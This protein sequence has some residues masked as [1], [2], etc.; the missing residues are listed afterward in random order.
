MYKLDPKSLLESKD[1]IFLHLSSYKTPEKKFDI[2]MALTREGISEAIGIGLTHTY[3]QINRLKEKG[4]I[5]TLKGRARGKSRNQEFFYLSSKGTKYA[6]NLKKK[7][8]KMK[9]DIIGIPDFQDR[10]DLDSALDILKDADFHELT[11]LDICRLTN[12]EGVLDVKKLKKGK[13]KIYVEATSGVPEIIHFFGRKDEVNTIRKW[14]SEK[15]KHNIIFIHGMAGIGKTTLA[16]RILEDYHNSKH[17]FWHEFHEMD[18]I[19]GI[20]LKLAGFFTELGD[21][22]LELFLRTRTGYDHYE[23]SRILEKTVKKLDAILVFDDFQKSSDEIRKFFVYFLGI[24]SP[25]SNTKLMILSREIVPFYDSRA[26]IAKKTVGELSLEGL[27]FESSKKLLKEKGVKKG[28]YKDIYGITAGNPLFLEVFQTQGHLDR[29]VHDELFAK[30]EKKEKRILSCLSV[31]RYPVKDVFLS[32]CD[33]L[34][35][36]TLYNLNRKSIVKK[37][38]YDRYFIHD[39]LKNFFYSRLS[40]RERNELH[41]LIAQWYVND[42]E[43]ANLIEAIYHYQEADQVNEAVKVSMEYSNLIIERGMAPDFLVLLN[44]FEGKDLETD[45]FAEILYIKGKSSYMIGE[46][47]KGLQYFS[48][49]SDLGA[50]INNNKLAIKAICESGYILEEYNVMDKSIM[51][52]EKGLSISKKEKYPYGVANSH[53]GIG[54]GYWRTSQLDKAISNY[55]KSLDI[56]LKEGFD[57]LTG[58]TYIDLGNA[59]DEKC[60]M[61]KA[62]ECYDRSIAFL[63]NANNITETARAYGNLGVTYRHFENYEKAIELHKMQLDLLK[64]SHHMTFVGY[65]YAWIGFCYSKIN[66]FKNAKKY[67]KKAQEIAKKIENKNILFDVFKTYAYILAKDNKWDE[68]MQYYQKSIDDAKVTNAYFPIAETYFEIG[69]LYKEGGFEKEGKRNFELALN[70]YKKLGLDKSNFIRTKMQLVDIN[71]A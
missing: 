48:E 43:A 50:I 2:P 19:R 15:D 52:F 45:T 66:D 28:R 10:V 17:L 20:L 34:D 44:R 21:D 4:Y 42:K 23:I 22:H 13:R 68:A 40:K 57:N 8:K 54:R 26:V 7:L 3:R 12:Q 39:I 55:R 24:L 51:T 70:F 16:A 38:S 32:S 71:I 6:Q 60:E 5:K 27:D 65:A 53:R 61:S 29:F 58:S 59:Y 69:Q 49:C 37:D 1:R 35:Y 47:K 56:S 18:A 11:L 14:I 67:A 46:W 63:K 25:T 64:G 30:L 36:D 31:Y 62:I 33:D 41:H 9:I